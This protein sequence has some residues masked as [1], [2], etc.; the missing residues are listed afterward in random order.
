MLT[1]ASHRH[2][3]HNGVQ[4]NSR[5]SATLIQRAR[6]CLAEPFHADQGP[7]CATTMTPSTTIHTMV[8]GMNTF[9]PSRM[10]WS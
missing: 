1:M 3:Q 2:S 9:Q 10:I 5:T 4:I 6:A 7:T 8:T